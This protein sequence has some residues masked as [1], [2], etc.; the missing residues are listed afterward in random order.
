MA[1]FNIPFFKSKNKSTEDLYSEGVKSI[2][3]GDFY[4]ANILFKKS[5]DEGHISALYNLAL[6]NGCGLIS[7]YDIDFA[8]DC[9]RQAA[10]KGHSKAKE[11]SFWLDKADDTS[12]GTTA[13]AMFASKLPKD[14]TP[15]HL[16]MMTGCRLYN[17]LCKTHQATADVLNY[18]LDAATHS[19]Y[20]FVHNFLDR[21][22]IP[23]SIYRGGLDKIKNNSPADQITDGLNNLHLGLKKS[24][25]SDSLCIMIRCSIVG[26]IISKSEYGN[27]AEPLL[28]Y[29]KF[30][31]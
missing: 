24:G 11:Y 10:L 29:D 21:T 20:G 12:F 31:D 25:H 14:N 1:L 4:S 3:K 15:N 2:Q 18:E 8:I 13:L 28:G 19:D 7:P 26:Y 9:Y 5:S 22:G 30:F 16:L 6:I 23:E 27:L 17:S